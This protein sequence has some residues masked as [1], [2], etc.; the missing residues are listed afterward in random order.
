MFTA[1]NA[2]RG[3]AY[4]PRIVQILRDHHGA[5]AI[6]SMTW[7]LFAASHLS[8]VAY[9]LVIVGDWHMGAVFLLNAICCLAV[10]A[11][12]MHKRRRLSARAE[13]PEH[14]SLSR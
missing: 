3:F 8:T 4:R 1:T 5:K 12:T 9:A 6:S 7:G 14:L 13:A 2:V 11:A 10:I